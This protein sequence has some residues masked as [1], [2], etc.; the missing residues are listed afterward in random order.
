MLW[1]LLWGTKHPAVSVKFS[2][3][4][5]IEATKVKTG[6]IETER[7]HSFTCSGRLFVFDISLLSNGVYSFTVA[8]VTARIHYNVNLAD[9]MSSSCVLI[10]I[11]CC[12]GLPWAG[13]GA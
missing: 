9:S 3:V 13:R 7:T 10:L 12:A 2:F 6:R 4:W 5:L 11:S 8:Q 1:E